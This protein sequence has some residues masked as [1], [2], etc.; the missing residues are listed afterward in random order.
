MGA[1]FFLAA[2][3]PFFDGLAAFVAF[4]FA[5]FVVDAESAAPLAPFEPWVSGVTGA[6][7][8]TSVGSISPARA[9][10]P[11]RKRDGSS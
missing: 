7:A 8:F 2:F 6:G 10:G 1:F 3:L 9:A 11:A 4:A 5:P